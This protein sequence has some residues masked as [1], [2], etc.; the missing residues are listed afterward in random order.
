MK[1]AS[2]KKFPQEAFFFPGNESATVLLE[3]LWAHGFLKGF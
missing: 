2:K 3:N 1:P